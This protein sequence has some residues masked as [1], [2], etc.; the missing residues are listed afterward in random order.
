MKN[1]PHFSVKNLSFSFSRKERP[2]FDSLEF[3]LSPASLTFVRGRNGIGKSLLLRILSG[4]VHAYERCTGTI[5]LGGKEYEL[6]GSQAF[7]QKYRDAVRM[8]HQKFDLMI[9]DQFSFIENIHLARLPKYPG[10]R[11]QAAPIT[12]PTTLNHFAIDLEK[13]VHLLSG[14][15]RQILATTMAIQKSTTVLLLDEPTAA[16][17]YQNARTVMQFLKE[18]TQTAGLATIVI[19]HDHELV[20]QF[21]EDHYFEL[22]VDENTATRT[23]KKRAI[24]FHYHKEK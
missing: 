1:Q 15:Q 13:P 17:D 10:L 24:T 2:F 21:A 23:L 7:P 14:G 19:S 20:E 6:G 16:L 5:T 8:V 4:N 18:L 22:E 11:M 12:L 3:T 9:A